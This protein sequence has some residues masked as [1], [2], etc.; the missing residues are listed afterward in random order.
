M[1]AGLALCP[2]GSL[3]L[4]PW[5]DL[6]ALN[7]APSVF[8]QRQTAVRLCLPHMQPVRSPDTFQTDHG[9]GRPGLTCRQVVCGPR[10]RMA[11]GRWSCPHAFQT[12]R[13]LGR[14]DLTRRQTAKPPHPRMEAEKAVGGWSCL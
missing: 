4:Q 13:G 14:P 12:D 8:Q 10:P 1:Y 9:L 5:A 7:A 3:A 6:C 2:A 11:A